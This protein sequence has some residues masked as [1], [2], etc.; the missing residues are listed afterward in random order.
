VKGSQRNQRD[1]KCTWL[2]KELERTCMCMESDFVGRGKQI[3]WL[4]DI[5]VVV[6]LNDINRN[7]LCGIDKLICL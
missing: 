5:G 7:E 3:A 2:T 4:D 6:K 1:E